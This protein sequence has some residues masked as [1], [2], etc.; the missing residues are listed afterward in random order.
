MMVLSIYKPKAIKAIIQHHL[1]YQ[2]P[3]SPMPN[4]KEKAN[5]EEKET[6]HYAHDV[7]GPSTKR[8]IRH[9]FLTFIHFVFFFTPRHPCPEGEAFPWGCSTCSTC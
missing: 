1:V 3:F 5:I 2:K 4:T 8:F 6:S 9:A 7:M